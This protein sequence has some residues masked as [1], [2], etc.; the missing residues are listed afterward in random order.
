MS[1]FL[2]D[3]HCTETH[4]ICSAICGERKVPTSKRRAHHYCTRTIETSACLQRPFKTI[5]SPESPQAGGPPT[6]TGMRTPPLHLPMVTDDPVH[7]GGN[8][9]PPPPLLCSPAVPSDP[10][11]TAAWHLGPAPWCGGPRAL[12]VL[13]HA[14]SLSLCSYHMSLCPSAARVSLS[15]LA[16]C[17]SKSLCAASA[18]GARTYHELPRACCT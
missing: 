2:H 4:R 16:S 11:V 10:V 5:G 15:A 8:G 3:E 14:Q 1:I 13:T 17:Y 6:E 7:V 18:D 12:G 9:L